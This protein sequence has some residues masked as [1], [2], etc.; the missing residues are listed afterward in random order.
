MIDYQGVAVQFDGLYCDIH[1]EY[2]LVSV[3]IDYIKK[4]LSVIFERN[5]FSGALAIVKTLR[6]EAAG[7]D[8]LNININTFDINN[9]YVEEIGYKKCED[10][11]VDYLLNDDTFEES[12]HLVIYLGS[13]SLDRN[14][15]GI[16]RLHSSTLVAV[17]VA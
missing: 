11:G 2:D 5:Q 10:F 16:I 13:K 4:T 3:Y 7:I 15:K 17:Q 12:N 14:S 8:Y 6:L 1:N 9:E